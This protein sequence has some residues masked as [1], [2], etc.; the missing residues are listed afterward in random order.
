MQHDELQCDVRAVRY[1]FDKKVGELFMDDGDCCDFTGCID[2]FLRI[3]PAVKRINTFSGEAED[4]IY[5]R[6][7]DGKWAASMPK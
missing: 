7:R 2:L 5:V 4:T 1:D 3:D 6:D